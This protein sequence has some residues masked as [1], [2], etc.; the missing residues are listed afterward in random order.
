MNLYEDLV[1]RFID[2][3]ND[4]CEGVDPAEKILKD[5]VAAFEQVCCVE[6][7]MTQ[8]NDDG[9]E[10]KDVEVDWK[11]PDVVSSVVDQMLEQFDEEGLLDEDED[12]PHTNM[13]I[14]GA[15]RYCEDCDEVFED[16]TGSNLMGG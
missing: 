13:N 4:P 15:G 14:S 8:E 5:F 10:E 3:M 16:N 6:K 1:Y 7:S 2:R 9:V 12:C 11:D